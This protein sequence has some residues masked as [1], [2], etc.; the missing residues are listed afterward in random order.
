MFSG[1]TSKSLT[2]ASCPVRSRRE[3]LYFC[4]SFIIY[5]GVPDSNQ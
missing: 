3:T 5:V 4:R 2:P 1:D